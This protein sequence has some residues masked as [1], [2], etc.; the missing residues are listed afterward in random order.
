MLDRDKLTLNSAENNSVSE[1][2]QTPS[3]TLAA[4]S[5]V[6]PVSALLLLGTEVG[7]PMTSGDVR[8]GLSGQA[9][10]SYTAW[11][12]VHTSEMEDGGSLVEDGACHVVGEETVLDATTTPSRFGLLVQLQRQNAF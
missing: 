6:E 2:V 5:H 3:F 1:N 4:R 8:A 7:Q 12:I 10:R 9:W 11:Q